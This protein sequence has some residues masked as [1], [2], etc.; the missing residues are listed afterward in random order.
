MQGTIPTFAWR[1]WGKPRRTAVGI[2]GVRTEI[3]TGDIPNSKHYDIQWRD[4]MKEI[5]KE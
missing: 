4:R 5:N 1:D 2:A 3:W